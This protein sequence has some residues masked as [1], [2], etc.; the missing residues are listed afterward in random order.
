MSKNKYKAAAMKKIQQQYNSRI[1][2]C[3]KSDP[4][5]S[6]DIQ[7]ALNKLQANISSVS[8]S[9]Q[10]KIISLTNA[11][12]I[13]NSG[14]RNLNKLIN[15]LNVKLPIANRTEK[16][17][18]KI[19]ADFEPIDT[20]IEAN[21]STKPEACNAAAEFKSDLSV[22]VNQYI[23]DGKEHEFRTLCKGALTKANGS[24]LAREPNW[25]NGIL[26]ALKQFANAVIALF[27]QDNSSSFFKS[28]AQDQLSKIKET[29]RDNLETDDP[30]QAASLS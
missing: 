15:E 29:V 23:Q 22:A 19:K 11:M 13:T 20:W 14:T 27:K 10:P 3:K 30:A 12:S 2:A 5:T 4:Q 6:A 9:G 21:K 24:A 28:S 1:N 18:P 7:A 26:P 25:R 17:Q 8:R 16:I